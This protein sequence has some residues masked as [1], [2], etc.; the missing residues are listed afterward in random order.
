[1][2]S[3]SDDWILSDEL[4]RKFSFR[5]DPDIVYMYVSMYEL[6]SK[7]SKLIQQQMPYYM[8]AALVH[9]FFHLYN[10][11]DRRRLCALCF[12][13]FCY[14][15]SCLHPFHLLQIFSRP[16]IKFFVLCNQPLNKNSIDN[17]DFFRFY[18]IKIQLK[19][20][21]TRNCPKNE[22]VRKTGVVLQR[23]CGQKMAGN[24]NVLQGSV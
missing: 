13:Y 21:F 2:R 11:C 22:C 9:I 23:F 16:I 8:A 1:M 15:V 3:R 4:V 24:Q 6:F 7:V 14:A 19:F 17:K 18:Q 5:I 20:Y 10:Y 12:S